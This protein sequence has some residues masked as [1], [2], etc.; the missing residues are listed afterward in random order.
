MTIETITNLSA[1]AN[2]HPLWIALAVLWTIV[3]KGFALWRAA[4]LQQRYWF[5]V[6]LLINT[7]GV[8]EIIYLFFIARNYKVEIIDKSR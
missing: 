3:W 6:L 2:I 5:L 7:L 8:L 4:T 1:L